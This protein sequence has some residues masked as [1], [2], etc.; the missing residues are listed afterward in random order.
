MTQV[1][2]HSGKVFPT[3][4]EVSPE[5]AFSPVKGLPVSSQVMGACQT[6]PGTP[7]GRCVLDCS[8]IAVWKMN[9]RGRAV[10]IK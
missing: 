7:S 1:E 2:L 6:P 4:V 9:T 10:G 8:I 3:Q 5:L